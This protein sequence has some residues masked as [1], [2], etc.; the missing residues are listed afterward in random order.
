[1]VIDLYSSGIASNEF[2]PVDTSSVMIMFS[3]DGS[4]SRI[5]YA[6]TG[7]RPPSKVYLMIGRREKVSAVPSDP[8]SNWRDPA[9]LW[10]SIA[11][12]SGQVT[13]SENLATDPAILDPGVGLP[14]ARELAAAGQQIGGR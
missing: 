12:Q 6:G 7:T 9:S 4:M 10:V 3:P 14:L 11:P 5:Y 2:A 8:N 1:V 13:T